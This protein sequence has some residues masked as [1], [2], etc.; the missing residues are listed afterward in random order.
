MYDHS[1]SDYNVEDNVSPDKAV[2][3]SC[4]CDK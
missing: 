3:Q 2:L 1:K 4:K